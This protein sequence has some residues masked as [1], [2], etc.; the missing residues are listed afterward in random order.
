M[1]KILRQMLV[2]GFKD[3]LERVE[4][5]DQAGVISNIQDIDVKVSN[6]SNKLLDLQD[7]ARTLISG[8]ES[9][10]RDTISISEA[11]NAIK[12]QNEYVDRL[13]TAE[14]SEVPE[15]LINAMKQYFIPPV[16][17]IDS[18]CYDLSTMFS[19][20]IILEAYSLIFKDY[21]HT[22]AG[23]ANEAFIAGLLGG[24]TL[25]PK[26]G[27]LADLILANGDIG[28]SLKTID[29]SKGL[30]ASFA[31]L[32]RT[33]GIKYKSEG[34]GKAYS[35]TVDAPVHNKGLYYLLFN[36]ETDTSHTIKVFKV[37]REEFIAKMDELL[38]KDVDG[39]YVIPN[40]TYEN[41]LANIAPILGAKFSNISDDILGVS[42][43]INIEQK[44]DLQQPVVENAQ[45][46][47]ISK[48]LDTLSLLNDFYALYTNSVIKFTTEPS[49]EN[50]NNLKEQF[51]EM[52]KID[53]RSL[54]VN[55]EC[56]N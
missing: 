11:W 24:T 20:Y 21:S 17:T 48:I 52:S 10:F 12:S 2:E 36:K 43:Y 34:K 7:I 37:N 13:K 41:K 51:L 31:T 8:T 35:S 14:E 26:S 55:S 45:S 18:S 3:I 9:E 46:T 42:N 32:M 19:R 56:S 23:Y 39:T 53:P 49:L 27:T 44:I 40:E 50:L 54:V 25:P 22:L 38:E 16:D 5:D 4:Y 15:L 33:L 6:Q 30:D 47:N 1:D 29:A 28:I